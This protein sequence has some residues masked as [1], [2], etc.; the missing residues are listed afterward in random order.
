MLLEEE[1]TRRLIR[2]GVKRDSLEGFQATYDVYGDY[3]REQSDFIEGVSTHI[4]SNS[5]DEAVA[6]RSS[7]H[8]ERG[9]QEAHC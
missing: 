8:A 6:G 7:L 3:C 9:Y 2:K 4:I 1:L 5:L